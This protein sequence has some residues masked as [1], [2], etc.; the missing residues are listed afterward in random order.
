LADDLADLA[1][2]EA[3]DD[4]DDDDDEQ[5]EETLVPISPVTFATSD[6]PDVSEQFLQEDEA[7][8]F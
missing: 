7:Q 6:P 4:D 8:E 1:V 2:Q 3:D 5:V